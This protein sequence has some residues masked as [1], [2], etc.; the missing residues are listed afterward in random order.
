MILLKTMLMKLL[1]KKLD[2]E[3]VSFLLKEKIYFIYIMIIF[4][5]KNI[6]TRKKLIIDHIKTLVKNEMNLRRLSKEVIEV[7]NKFADRLIKEP[8]Y[9]E[10]TKDFIKGPLGWEKEINYSK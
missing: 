8:N 10:L 5:T 4:K 3:L 2:L 6:F 9:L 7:I 1:I